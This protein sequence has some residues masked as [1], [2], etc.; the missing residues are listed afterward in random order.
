[1]C[2]LPI[3]KLCTL[4]PLPSL[5]I[6]TLEGLGELWCFSEV[7]HPGHY[8]THSHYADKTNR[9]WGKGC[10]LPGWGGEGTECESLPWSSG[11]LRGMLCCWLVLHLFQC[12]LN[13]P[14]PAPGYEPCIL[15]T[16]K[17]TLLDGGG[18]QNHGCVTSD[19]CKPV[20]WGLQWMAFES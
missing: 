7:S 15:C 16:E 4:E 2:I 8:W 14:C 6:R 18:L 10:R 19:V 12:Y 1:M 17:P 3:S 9:V 11:I 20:C 5:P 13:P